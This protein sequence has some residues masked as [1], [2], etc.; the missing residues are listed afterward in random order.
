MNPFDDYLT[1]SEI[2]LINELKGKNRMEKDQI[3]GEYENG[4]I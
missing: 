4:E 1:P 2:R 3:I